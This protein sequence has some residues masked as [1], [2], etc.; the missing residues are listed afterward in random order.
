MEEDL[1]ILRE[2]KQNNESKAMII[3]NNTS[4]LQITWSNEDLKNMAEIQHR[5]ARENRAIDNLIQSYK[6][7]E[8]ENKELKDKLEETNQRL[9]EIE[10][11]ILEED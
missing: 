1:K 8:E 11:Q 2:I 7:L 10:L 5:C 4:N 9:Q 3:H 6:K